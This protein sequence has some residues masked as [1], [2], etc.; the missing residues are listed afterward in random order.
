M[1]PPRT[2]APPLFSIVLAAGASSRFGSPKQLLRVAGRPLLHTMVTRAAEVTGAA[3]IVVLGSGA[4]EL[5]PLLKHSPGSLVIN[6]EWREGLASSI[7]AGI[8]RLPATCA[9]ALLVLADQAAVTA[10]DLLRLAGTW[11]RQ[12]QYIAAASYAGTTGV[13]AIF[14]R[15]LFRELGEL[16]GDIG[17]RTL[18]RRNAARVVRVS[19]PSAALDVDTPEDLLG[20]SEPR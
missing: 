3:L 7:R 13:P 1:S 2:R 11:R 10:D 5:A 12:P 14:P 20:L 6:Q 19:M 16:R 17:A 15:T 4:E 8:A 18:L 9:G